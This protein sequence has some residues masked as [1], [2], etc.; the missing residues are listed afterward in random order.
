MTQ[1]LQRVLVRIFICMDTFDENKGARQNK[2]R[3]Y[4]QGDREYSQM[5]FAKQKT[6]TLMHGD[7]S[8]NGEDKESQSI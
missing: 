7:V 5:L 6:K 4:S 1:S 2:K 3:G 8:E